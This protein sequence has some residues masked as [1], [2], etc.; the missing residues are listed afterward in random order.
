[1][2]LISP[3]AKGEYDYYCMLQF[4]WCTYS[5]F[6]YFQRGFRE[7]YKRVLLARS[8]IA[9]TDSDYINDDIFLQHLQHF[10]K[11][12]SPGED[13]H[14]S[15]SWLM[16]FSCC[17]QTGIETLFLYPHTTRHTFFRQNCVQAHQDI[18]SLTKFVYDNPNTAI[19]KFSF[20]KLFSSAWKKG[21]KVGNVARG[22]ECTGIFILT[23]PLSP[24]T[25]FYLLHAF[26]KIQPTSLQRVLIY[27]SIPASGPPVLQSTS[28]LNEAV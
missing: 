15:Y 28:D 3:V 20:G 25:N 24:K 2:L 12:R 10:Q 22:F 26:Y 6:C 11:H 23:L 17:T 18:L 27:D 1:M 14:S 8:E 9:T 5:V 4:K 13:R 21:T 19:G 7:I 16:S